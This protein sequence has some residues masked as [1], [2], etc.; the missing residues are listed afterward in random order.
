MTNLK[1]LFTEYFDV[2]E[3]NT[4]ELVD[5]SMRIRYQVYCVENQFEKPDAFPDQKEIDEYDRHSVHSVIRHKRTELVA[6]TVR[7]VLPNPED[8]T[9]PFPIEKFCPTD[10]SSAGIDLSTIPRQEIAE[11]SRFAVSK[12]FK[13]RLDEQGTISGVGEDVDSYPDP[14]DVQADKKALRMF[15]HISLGLFQGIVRMSAEHDIK[16]WYAV[17][18]PPLLRL[19]TRFGIRFTPFG[20]LMDYHG[21]RQPCFGNA[22]EILAGIYFH[23]RDVWDLITDSGR[24]WPSPEKQA[25]QRIA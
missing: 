10:I 15:P 18:E 16:F 17:M 4:P 14:A 25:E 2:C 8:A 9:I 22:D 1:Q 5:E 24:T 7:L 23:R 11:I 19:L 3:A 21:L 12:E 20:P 6:A 13:R